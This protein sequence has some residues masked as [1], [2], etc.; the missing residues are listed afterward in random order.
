MVLLWCL[1][2]GDIRL[3]PLA[4]V[5]L[6]FTAQQH[7]SVLPT[8]GLASIAVGVVIAGRSL[9]S[10]PWRDPAA[11][12]Q[13]LRWG[14]ISAVVAGLLW[15]P[16]LVQQFFASPPNLTALVQYS[17]HDD[18]PSLGYGVAVRQVAHVLGWPPILG[19]RNLSGSW[20]FHRV[21]LVTWLTTGMVVVAG[22]ILGWRWRRTQPRRAGLVLMAGV[23]AICGLFSGASVPVGKEQT[24]L[25]FYHWAPA[26]QFFLVTSLGLAAVAAIDRLALARRP[27][28]RA[29]AVGVLLAAIIGTSIVSTTI[30]RWPNTLLAAYSPYERSVLDQVTDQVM[31]HRSEFD[32][33]EVVLIA[34]GEA[35][36]VGIHEAL[37]FEMNL[38]GVAPK[39]PR[40]DGIFV[41]GERLVDRDTVEAGLV[42]VLDTADGSRTNTREKALPPDGAELIADVAIPK[43]SDPGY[44]YILRSRGTRIRV[45]LLD[46]DELLDWGIRRELGD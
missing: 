38:R 9:R 37:A 41:A 6:S 32:D 21:S 29:A 13:L 5:F 33:G 40:Y 35:W 2:C 12:R 44:E 19:Q 7:L 17:T 8:V 15:L 23:L 46:R 26:A 39:H 1:L 31:D 45:Y 27:Q 4:A 16:V 28:L 24:R 3:L 11:R 25:A 30:H 34:R 43:D 14:R 42:M 36:H 22:G 10:R 18:R 20:L